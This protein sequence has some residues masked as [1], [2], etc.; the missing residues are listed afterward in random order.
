VAGEH[1]GHLRKASISLIRKDRS[2]EPDRYHRK[3]KAAP[4]DRKIEYTGTI[5]RA[6]SQ[7]VR[8]IIILMSDSYI[9]H[10]RRSPEQFRRHQRQSRSPFPTAQA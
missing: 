7:S 6:P 1:S 9:E 3:H 5:L 8:K 10:V 4:E 2:G